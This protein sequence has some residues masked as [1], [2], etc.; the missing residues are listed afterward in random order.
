VRELLVAAAVD[1]LRGARNAT[2]AAMRSASR[3]SHRWNAAVSGARQVPGIIRRELMPSRVSSPLDAPLGRRRAVAWT[4]APLLALH[5]AAKRVHP[6]ATLNDAVI[7]LVASGVRAWLLSQHR[8]LATL[9]V[10]IPVSLHDPN[11]VNGDMGNR[12][13]FIDV[14]APMGAESIADR[15]LAVSAQ[16]SERK[17]LH[18]AEHLD[19][20]FRE[21][22]ALPFGSHALAMTAGANEFALCVSNVPG[23]R[24]PIS[25]LGHRVERFY[26]VVEIA[27]HHDLRVSVLSLA[28]VMSFT[29]CAEPDCVDPE[30]VARGIDLA[31]TELC[32][33]KG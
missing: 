12:D 18:D 6:E 7:A 9:R 25:V 32:G 26:S 5:A 13:S 20:L 28:G 3:D 17:R 11:A 1:R 29:L 21:I 15:V 31:I 8:S 22:G 2:R 16:T 23:P 10:R 19:R 27:P 33:S 30:V 24:D 14:D 4:S